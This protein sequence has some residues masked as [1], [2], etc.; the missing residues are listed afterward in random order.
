MNI[1]GSVALITGANRGLGHA[2][3]Q[4]LLAAGASK[5][6]AAARDP[7]SITVPGVHP[8]KLDVTN[9]DDV[10][11]AAKACPDVTLVINNAG[12][13]RNAP[14]LSSDTPENIRAQMETNFYGTLAVG[15]AFAPILKA[16]GGGAM[17]NILSVLSWVAV[18]GTALYSASKA[19][20]WALTNAFRKELRAN[21]TLVVG[22]HFGYMDTSMAAHVQAPKVDPADVASQVLRA[23]DAGQEEVLADAL[24]CQVKAGLSLEP[25]IYLTA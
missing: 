7:S 14:I 1:K 11:A 25:A 6:Y 13:Y 17:V 5:V 22:V 24:S 12:I 4:A 3:A 19:A 20:A 16:N 15:T 9:P 23:V 2:F 21:G 8:I 10:A 18:S